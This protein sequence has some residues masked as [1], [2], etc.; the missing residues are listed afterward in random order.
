MFKNILKL[1][2]RNIWKHKRYSFINIFGFSLGMSCVIILY[3]YI[4]GELSSDKFHQN[5]EQIYRV[6]RKADLNGD[7][8]LIGIT[9]GP[10]APA[11]QSD[12]EGR[13]QSTMRVM[14][15]NALIN[16]EDKTFREKKFFFADAHFFEFFSFPLAEGSSKTVLNQPNALVLSQEMANKYFGEE[17]PIGKILKIDQEHSFQVTGVLGDMPIHSHLDFDFVASIDFMNRFE[18]FKDWWSNGLLT[19]VQIETP[20]IAQQVEAQFPAFMDKY[21]G[22]DFKRSGN[23]MDLALQPLSEVYFQAD[24]R[25]DFALHGNLQTVYAKN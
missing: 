23:R 10:F 2:F 5:K 22:A 14:P 9:S 1:S 8:Y 19:Y 3:A 24:V 13:I 7:N 21:L 25:Y 17:N 6:L 15:E 11:L 18:H 4:Y 20:A 16:Y 12:F